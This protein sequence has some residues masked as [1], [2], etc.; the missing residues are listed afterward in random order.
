MEKGKIA[1]LVNNYA[2]YFLILLFG[3]LY[4]F[5]AITKYLHYQTGLDLAIYV[6]TFWFYTHFKLPYVTLYPTFG[7]LVWAD[8]FSPS[9]VL[10]TPLYFLWKDPSAL[11]LFQSFL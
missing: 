4:S 3:A 7:D 8:H 10:L 6:Q 9:L 2:I 5:I 1:V 11:L